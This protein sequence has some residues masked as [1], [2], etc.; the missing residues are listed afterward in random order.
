MEMREA[1]VEELEGDARSSS[2]Q[3]GSTDARFA[4]APSVPN[5]PHSGKTTM[6]APSSFAAAVKA[7][8]LTRLCSMTEAAAEPGEGVEDLY[9]TVAATYEAVQAR[10]EASSSRAAKALWRGGMYSG[11]I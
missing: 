4:T 11:T 1:R 6:S 3:N 5:R 9:C 2:S 8:Y 7:L 10:G